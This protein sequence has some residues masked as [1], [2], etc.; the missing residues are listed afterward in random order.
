MGLSSNVL[1]MNNYFNPMLN[2]ANQELGPNAATALNESERK[3]SRASSSII[4]SLLGMM[5]KKGHNIRI[6]I[7]L[8]EAGRKNM[9]DNYKGFRAERPASGQMKVSDDFLQ[10]LLGDKAGDFTGAIAKENGMSNVATNRLISMIVPLFCGFLGNKL[11]KESKTMSILLK[12]IRNESDEFK[13][14]IPPAL[15]SS[16]GL[17]PVFHAE[18]PVENKK[19]NAGWSVW[20]V[21]IALLLVIFFGW[22]YYEQ[23]EAQ[24]LSSS[25]V[26]ADTIAQNPYSQSPSVPSGRTVRVLTLPNNERVNVYEDG[27]EV[28]MVEFLQSDEYGK[29]T[30]EELK[31]KWFW[32]DNLAFEPGSATVLKSGYKE[33]LDNIAAILK[34]YPEARIAIVSFTDTNEAGTTNTKV[35]QERARTIESLLERRGVGSQIVK[36]HGADNGFARRNVLDSVSGKAQERVVVLRLV[37]K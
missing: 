8:E 25:T 7:I 32:F 28:Y 30:D 23:E 5:L 4:A 27:I 13:S 14:M 31:K 35:S 19:S 29:A 1:I 3:I 24:N 22:R 20:M 15:I 12:E 17:S 9:L 6:N 36:H 2:L 21:L 34:N 33:Q 11:V 37:K 16:F 10:L 18:A 26:M